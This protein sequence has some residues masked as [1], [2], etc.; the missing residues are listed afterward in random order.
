[1][2]SGYKNAIYPYTPS[3]ASF[4]PIVI[5]CFSRQLWKNKSNGRKR[6]KIKAS[7]SCSERKN[8]IQEFKSGR[9]ERTL[10]RP[11]FGTGSGRVVTQIIE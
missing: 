10:W 11:R 9:V 8:R 7:T 5:K 3:V 4:A 2:G 1:M 6:K